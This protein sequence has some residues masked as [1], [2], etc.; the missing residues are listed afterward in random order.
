MTIFARI[1]FAWKVLCGDDL[2]L[3]HRGLSFAIATLEHLESTF[4]ESDKVRLVRH[5]AAMRRLG[6]VN[7]VGQFARTVDGM[8]LSNGV[9]PWRPDF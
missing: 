9:P 6:V 4:P 3:D 1:K 5:E 8:L 7:D 2:E